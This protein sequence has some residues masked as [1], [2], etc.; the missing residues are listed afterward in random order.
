MSA[1]IELAKLSIT[2]S[3]GVAGRKCTIVLL[4]RSNTYQIKTIRQTGKN[5]ETWRKEIPSADVMAQ[6]EKL[7]FAKIPAFPVSPQV[8]D[9]SYLELTIHGELS[10]VILG[11][12]TIA[13][14]GADEVAD[15]ADWLCN[16]SG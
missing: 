5:R 11:W 14:D 6:L 3:M 12:W 7:R 16:I 2:P 4:Q 9:G 10:T 1:D 8:C 13:P 15:F